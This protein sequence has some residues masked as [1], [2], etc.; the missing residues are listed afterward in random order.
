M[1]AQLLI[2][3]GEEL[4]ER[5]KDRAI[6]GCDSRPELQ[7]R[8]AKIGPPSFRRGRAVQLQEWGSTNRFAMHVSEVSA[9]VRAAQAAVS[10]T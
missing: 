3:S 2:V 1:L 8:F 4:T 9:W 10:V 5:S 6:D 7:D